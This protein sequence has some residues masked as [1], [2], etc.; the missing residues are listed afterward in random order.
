MTVEVE[1][2]DYNLP[3]QELEVRIAR[4]TLARVYLAGAGIEVG[5]GSS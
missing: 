1:V 4:R 3:P 5:A 2:V